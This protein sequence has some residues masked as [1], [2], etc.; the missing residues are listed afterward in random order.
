MVI[1]LY[2]PRVVDFK[3]TIMNT[4]IS[5]GYSNESSNSDDKHLEKVQLQFLQYILA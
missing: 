3:R 1:L 2:K 4:I 5:E